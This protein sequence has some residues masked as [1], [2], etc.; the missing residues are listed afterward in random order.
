[1]ATKAMQKALAAF[2]SARSREAVLEALTMV[3]EAHPMREGLSVREMLEDLR[4]LVT[5]RDSAGLVL[6]Q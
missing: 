6:R 4:W 3:V 1:M 2:D 5:A